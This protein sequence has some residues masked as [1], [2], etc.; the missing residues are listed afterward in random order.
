LTLDLG[1]SEFRGVVSAATRRKSRVTML[2][3]CQRLTR[4]DDAMRPRLDLEDQQTRIVRR[5]RDWVL[6]NSWGGLDEP[7]TLETQELM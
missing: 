1:L 7:P 3:R 5:L 6:R 4:E 2:Y